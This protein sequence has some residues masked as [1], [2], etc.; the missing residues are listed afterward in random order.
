MVILNLSTITELTEST[1]TLL[2][3]HIRACAKMLHDSLTGNP[4][5]VPSMCIILC[6]DITVLKPS[7]LDFTVKAFC[8]L[9][10]ILKQCQPDQL[11][12]CKI[13][14]WNYILVLILLFP[15]CST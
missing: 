5:C 9:E 15:T 10:S 7:V 13:Q 12:N 6:P 3:E 1:V 11:E 2:L 8:L 14:I 4:Q